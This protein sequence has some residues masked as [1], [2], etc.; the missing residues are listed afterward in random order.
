MKTPANIRSNACFTLVELLVS[1]AILTLLLVMMASIVNQ[2]SSMWSNTRGKIE[3]FREARDGFEA[4]TRRISQATLNTYWDYEDASHNV[5]TPLTSGSF[6]PARYARQSELRFISGPSNTSGG[7]TGLLSSGTGVYLT[8]SIFFQAPLGVV[9]NSTSYG[10]LQYLLNTWGYYIEYDSDNKFRPSFVNI[11]PRNR[12]R[13][14]ELIQPSEAMSLYTYTSG[15]ATATQKRSGNWYTDALN[16]T[17]PPVHVLAENIIALVILPKLSSSDEKAGS[18]T[19]DSLAPKYIYNSTGYEAAGT[20]ALSTVS[21][22]NLNPRNQLPP[23][24]QVTM[25]AIDE[26]SAGRMTDADNV[27]LQ[28]ELDNLFV[29]AS[30]F[31]ANLK[32]TSSGDNSLE[33]YLIKKKINYRIFTTNVSIKGAKWS[34]A[35]TN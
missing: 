33:A 7:T 23:V 22:K 25:V 5:R 13:L 31:S 8:H 24:V 21:D 28:Q 18:Y 12:F 20:A 14:M 26:A 17:T 3:Q 11:Q 30:I 29:D 4:M 1:M 16:A 35:Q 15:S 9:D 34:R 27:A 32:M 2:T 6:T 10:G 19:D